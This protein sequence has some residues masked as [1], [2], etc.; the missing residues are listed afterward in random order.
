MHKLYIMDTV[1]RIDLEAKMHTRFEITGCKAHA[2]VSGDRKVY[3]FS[4]RAQVVGS[5]HVGTFYAIP[6]IL[7]GDRDPLTFVTQIYADMRA[8]A[9]FV[10]SAAQGQLEQVYSS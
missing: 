1:K 3:V 6:R 7:V 2:P 5:V 8:C 10:A 9:L 4:Y